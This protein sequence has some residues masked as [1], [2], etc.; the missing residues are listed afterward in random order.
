M[1]E[2]S[3]E[4]TR[5]MSEK[6]HKSWMDMFKRMLKI[7]P[8]WEKG[9]YTVRKVA[10]V[11][12]HAKEGKVLEG[13]VSDDLVECLRD[14]YGSGIVTNI[15]IV[16]H[17]KEPIDNPV[18]L[19]IGHQWGKEFDVRE[20]NKTGAYT[21]KRQCARCDKIESMGVCIRAGGSI[22]TIP[23]LGGVILDGETN[24]ENTKS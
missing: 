10:L 11:R 13:E 17:I 15:E 5:K 14:C 19:K 22:T 8:K 9:Q 18:C 21:A 3:I 16:A 23:T 4:R 20:L 1:P 24:G 2:R 7:K 6:K 12:V